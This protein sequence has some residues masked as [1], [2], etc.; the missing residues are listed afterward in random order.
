MTTKV[1]QPSLDKQ[2]GS[3]EMT[4]KAT[5]INS[6]KADFL[7]LPSTD[8]DCDSVDS[9]FGLWVKCAVCVS[10]MNN[11]ATPPHPFNII[12]SRVGRPFTLVQW[13]D[14]KDTEI[15]KQR[16]VS[17]KRS[18]LEALESNG[19]INRFESGSLNQ[20][21]KKQKTIQ[22]LP[23]APPPLATK[24]TAKDTCDGAD[25]MTTRTCEGII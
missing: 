7:A 22:F 4:T 8:P 12:A 2:R 19:T 25:F 14:H 18:G 5:L 20:L 3:D 6:S 21:R 9:K 11:K 1:A 23:K 10:I 24:V 15:H 16:L 13:T 17:L